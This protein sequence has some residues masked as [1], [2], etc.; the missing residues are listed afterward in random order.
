MVATIINKNELFAA[1]ALLESGSAKLKTSTK[2]L[3]A[4]TNQINTFKK[5]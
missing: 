5:K 1:Q 3:K 4:V 2:E